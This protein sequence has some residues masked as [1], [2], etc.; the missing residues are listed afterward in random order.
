MLV[1]VSHLSRRYG[2]GASAVPALH[3]VSFSIGAGEYVAIMGPSGSGK[4]TLINL[5]GLLDRPTSGSLCFAGVEVTRLSP[6]RLARIRNR[7]IGFIFQSYNL[8]SRYTALENVE[9]PLVYAGIR[10]SERRRLAEVTLERVGLRHRAWHWPAQLSG[11]EQQ[12]VAVARALVSQ[13]QLLLADEPTGALDSR[14]GLQI[15]ALLQSLNQAGNTILMVT[16][17]QHIASHASRILQLQDGALVDDRPVIDRS[18]A[19]VMLQAL[20]SPR[21][22]IAPEPLHAL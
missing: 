18:Y 2:A 9:L 16:H 5:I 3:D 14:M 21:L 19:E 15:L 6:D 12:R 7:D 17:D 1:E 11:G 10:R 13:P 4:T 22:E 8:L 20:G